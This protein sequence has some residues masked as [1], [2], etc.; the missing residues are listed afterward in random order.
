MSVDYENA[1]LFS[2]VSQLLLNELDAE[3]TTSISL[4]DDIIHGDYQLLIA[5]Q[6]GHAVGCVSYR[7]TESNRVDVRCLYIRTGYRHQ[8]L[9]KSLLSELTLRVQGQTES[10]IWFSSEQVIIQDLLTT[11]GYRDTVS[12]FGG[13]SGQACIGSTLGNLHIA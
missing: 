10:L 5:R 8:G 12:H 11:L 7:F 4:L 1:S 2:P 3:S 6:D 9:A 13:D